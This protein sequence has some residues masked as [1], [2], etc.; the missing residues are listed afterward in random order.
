MYTFQFLALGYWL[1]FL[2]QK[3]S[4][5]YV[6]AFCTNNWIHQIIPG[7][8][9]FSL[10]FE[11]V[12]ILG[13]F[14]TLAEGNKSLLVQRSWRKSWS[15]PWLAPTGVPLYDQNASFCIGSKDLFFM[16]QIF[17]HLFPPLSFTNKLLLTNI[18]KSHFSF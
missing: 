7:A 5:R 10:D 17:Y 3:R 9:F 11:R 12:V 1:N 16:S 8:G 2:Y 15:P 6:F 4:K 13:S 14:A 18:F